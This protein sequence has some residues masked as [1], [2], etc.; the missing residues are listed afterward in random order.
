ML[1]ALLLDSFLLCFS[2]HCQNCLYVAKVYF[3]K[4]LQNHI[5]D[6][7]SGWKFCWLVLDIDILYSQIDNWTF[8]SPVLGSRHCT[9]AYTET[10]D[11]AWR[12]SIPQQRYWHSTVRQ[13]SVRFNLTEDESA[14]CLFRSWYII[15]IWVY[16]LSNHSSK[17]NHFQ[18]AV[19]SVFRTLL[20]RAWQLVSVRGQLFLMHYYTFDKKNCAEQLSRGCMAFKMACVTVKMLNKLYSSEDDNLMSSSIYF[21]SEL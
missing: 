17:C 20:L 5:I 18:I 2:T 6:Y 8:C 3:K 14:T 11:P 19:V 15:N 21:N 4:S 13:G 1:F 10:A 7:K 12:P 9:R 16:I